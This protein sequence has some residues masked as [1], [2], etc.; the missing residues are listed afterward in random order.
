MRYLKTLVFLSVLGLCMQGTASA[1]SNEN[2][3]TTQ[4]DASASAAAPAEP[5]KTESGKVA[6]PSQSASSAKQDAEQRKSSSTASAQVKQSKDLQA[7]LRLFVSDYEV[8]EG[9]PIDAKTANSILAARMSRLGKTF[10]FVTTD[11]VRKVLDLSA[12]Q[13]MLGSDVGPEALV[14]LGEQIA[15]DRLVHGHMGRVGDTFVSTLTLYNL[16]T[17]KVEKRIA[18]TFKGAHDLAI[19]RLNEQAD[20]LLAHLLKNYAP[21]QLNKKRRVAVHLGGKHKASKKMHHKDTATGMQV[22]GYSAMALGLGL[23]AGAG[24]VHAAAGDQLD[25]AIPISI[26]VGAGA[27][28]I[29]GAVL[30]MWDP[31]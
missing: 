5:E 8:G 3:A 17:G 22:V 9:A 23:G 21:D 30:T 18:G 25:T 11:E 27:L 1:E 4:A 26:Y 20:Q 29:G 28:V 15:A 19:T 16:S 31:E 2:I 6:E 7:R 12:L 14:N 13:Q 10:D 24:L